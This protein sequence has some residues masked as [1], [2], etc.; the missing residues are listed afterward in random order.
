M[1]QITPGK[2]Y[3]PKLLC[4]FHQEQNLLLDNIQKKYLN[5]NADLVG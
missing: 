4:H 5:V 1:I 3:M 2:K